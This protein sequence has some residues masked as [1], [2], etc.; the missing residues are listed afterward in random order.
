MA[1]MVWLIYKKSQDFPHILPIRAILIQR[2]QIQIWHFCWAAALGVN[3]TVSIFL[4]GLVEIW[5]KYRSCWCHFSAI[6]LYNDIMTHFFQRERKWLI[7]SPRSHVRWM[8]NITGNK[9]LRSHDN[10]INDNYEVSILARVKVTD[11]ISPVTCQMDE[12]RHW[13]QRSEKPW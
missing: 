7:T 3:K 8:K 6:Q 4:I 10:D 11:Y 13:K 9:D 5:E 12:E 1:S 2:I